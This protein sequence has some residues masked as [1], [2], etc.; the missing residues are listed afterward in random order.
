[1]RQTCVDGSAVSFIFLMN[2]FY[3]RR[4]FFLVFFCNFQRIVFGSVIH[5]QDL[6]IFSAF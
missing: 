6:H 2:G 5:D 3:D 1:M 4:I